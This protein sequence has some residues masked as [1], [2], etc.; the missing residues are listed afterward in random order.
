MEKHLLFVAAASALCAISSL[1]TREYHFVYEQKTWHEAQSY[2]RERYTDLVTI[3]NMEDVNIL[4]GMANL[5]RLVYSTG[6]S[7]S[8]TLLLI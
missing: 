2:C 6:S 5:T 3:G 4:R 7:V 1:S 8:H